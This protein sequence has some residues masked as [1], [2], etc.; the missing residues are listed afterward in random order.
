MPS[1]LLEAL[2]LL[3]QGTRVTA[4]LFFWTALLAPAIALPVALARDSRSTASRRFGHGFILFF[5][6]APLLVVLF[7]LYYGLP[8]VNALRHSAL[9]PLLREPF[10]VAVL[11]LALNS[12]GF[13]AEIMA[14]ALRAVPLAEVEAATAAGFSRWQ[15]FRLIKLPNAA[16]I[17]LRS[18]GN[19][20]VFILKGT[21]VV[22]FI[23]I[24]DLMN[25]A[26]E[27]YS[28]TFDPITPLV[29]AGL[30]YLAMVAAVAAV[31]RTMERKLDPLL[32]AAWRGRR[33]A[34]VMVAISRKLAPT[35]H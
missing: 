27:I 29:S 25:A 11:A 30:I 28:R 21:A 16:R 22:S 13:Q 4:A 10:P 32:R 18:Y 17:G 5:R 26:T 20:L 33:S 34:A 9:W 1:R 23:T 15:I 8:Q 7:L 31:V 24:R 6:G 35:V 2:P 19:E 12:A 14:G 3:W